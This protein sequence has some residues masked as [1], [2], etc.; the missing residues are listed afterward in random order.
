M[1]SKPETHEKMW[2]EEKWIV[3]EEYCGKRML[4]RQG[5]YSSYHKH[6]SKKETFYVEGGSLELIHQGKH[7]IL[8]DGESLNINPREYHSFRAL[9]DTV[10]FEFS[11][12]HEDSDTYRL[13]QSSSGD[14]D[15]W[16]KEIEGVAKNG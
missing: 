14:H 4:I 10:F 11:T 7:L 1:K 16:K 5:F 9:E 3:N 6:D 2:G 15:K 12:H 13:T 8:H